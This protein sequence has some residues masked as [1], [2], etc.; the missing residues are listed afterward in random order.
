MIVKN[1]AHVIRRCLESVKPWITHW[2]IVDTGSTD[3]TQDE[4]RRCLG[5]LPGVLLEKPWVGFAT[6]RNQS[7]TAAERFAPDYLFVIDADEELVGNTG[8]PLPELTDDGYALE[9]QLVGEN[10]TW[11]RPCLVKAGRGWKYESSVGREGNELHEYLIAP[12]RPAST[13]IQGVTVKSY[14]DSARNTA[15]AQKKAARDAKLLRRGLKTSR[16]AARTW[17]YLARSLATAG[18]IDGAIVAY[19]RRAEFPDTL[20][21]ENWFALY[22][23]AGLRAARGDDWRDVAR[24]YLRAYDRRPQRAE[25]LWCLAQLHSDHKEFATAEMFARVACSKPVPPDVQPL[26]RSVY[27]W[28]VP[29]E[30]AVA[31]ANQGRLSEALAIVK[32]IESSPSL[33]HSEL[34][35][36]RRLA[37]ELQSAA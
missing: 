34:P 19:E 14:N 25:P 10:V 30:L 27:D 36:V 35:N 8:E 2:A 5:E 26:D 28:R 33:P 37:S 13:L 21:E 11:R 20:T 23:A 15:G 4:I 9:L 7:L 17:F 16:D 6:N 31:I 24:T 1:E 29:L 32:R 12:G 22:Q 18:D 3:G